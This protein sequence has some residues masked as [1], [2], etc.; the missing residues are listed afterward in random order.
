MLSILS[1][2]GGGVR[3]LVPG[4]VLEF[5]ESKLQARSNFSLNAFLSDICIATSAAPTYLPPHHFET[6]TTSGKP[7]KFNLLDGGLVANNPTYEAL[8]LLVG[9]NLDFF[10]RKSDDQNECDVMIISLG[11]GL[12][13]KGKDT[14]SGNVAKW[15]VLDWLYRHGSS[16]IID[17]FSDGN[18][19]SADD[20]TRQLL[21]T[22]KCNKK[23]LRIQDENLTGDLASVD[24]STKKNMD[25]LI[26]VGED[27]L[28]KPV[29]RVNSK[30]K[31]YEELGDG[32]S[33][34]DALTCCAKL[35]SD[36]RK[37][38]HGLPT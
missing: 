37:H 4:V 12:A 3:G 25:R 24:L 36:E 18:M 30:T 27:L 33:N 35:L 6:K 8:S 2:D 20:H 1:I 32:R 34:G 7:R 31:L 22:F 10:T 15:G 9:D 29:R 38:R 17:G 26:Q 28:K 16:P 13:K 19:A 23:F 14:D 11:T 5:L 21:E